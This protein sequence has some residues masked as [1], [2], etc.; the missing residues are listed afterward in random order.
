MSLD[1]A[2]RPIMAPSEK[3]YSTYSMTPSDA[4]TT[5]STDSMTAEIRPIVDGLERLKNPRLADQRVYLNEEK[6]TNLQKLALSA[7]LERA[8]DR[9]MSSQDAVMRPRKPS[10]VVTEKE[11]A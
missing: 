7:K 8:L 10:V 5:L 4:P 6:T 9:R 3:R 11:K 2:S 1:S